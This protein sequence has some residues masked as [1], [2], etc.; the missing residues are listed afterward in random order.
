MLDLHCHV[1]PGVDDGAVDLQDSLAL[2]DDAVEQGCRA[3][4][5]TSHLWESLFD[6]SPEVLQREYDGFV[7]AIRREGIPL[8]V[9]PGAENFLGAMTP[10]EFADR[11]VPLG[12]GRKYVLFDFSLRSV[13]SHVGETVKALLAAGRIPLIAHPER[14]LELQGDPTRVAEWIA[15]GARI[16]VNAASLVGL[17]GRAA[18]ESAEHL[19][20]A[21]A[22]HVLASDAHDRKRR[23]FCLRAG[24]D[25]AAEMLGEEEANRMTKERPWQIV[26]GETFSVPSVTIEPR[27][28]TRRFL[29]R[30]FDRL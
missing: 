24:R 6:T 18:Q 17:L 23:P 12:P 9:F 25:R 11:A 28:G 13:P 2:A 29:R 15:L 10:A 22:A 4:C 19:L 1:L 20:E 8:E 26:N 16:Q 30:L 7:K 27:S 21:G 3:I 5:A 14:N